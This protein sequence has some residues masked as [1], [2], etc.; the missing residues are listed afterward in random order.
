MDD[1]SPADRGLLSINEAKH[2]DGD[3]SGD[4]LNLQVPAKKGLSVFEA[5]LALLSAIVG[6]GIVGIPFAMIHTGIPLGVA[7][8]I[9]VAAA[10]CYTGSLYLK[11]KDLSPTY[12]ESMYELG[13]ITMGRASIYIISAII[14]LSGIGCIMI[15]FIV[16]GEISASLAV[17]ASDESSDSFFTKRWFY[18]LILALMMT[19]FCLK[20]MLSEMK[21]VSVLLFASIGLFILL[22][23]I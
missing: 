7:L 15:Y 13:F 6:G 16:F 14:K 10:G 4:E 20:K 2:S 12:V 22:F 21:I 17:L 11:C 8:N 23:I 5:G 18:V 1:V 3:D 9:S 19:P